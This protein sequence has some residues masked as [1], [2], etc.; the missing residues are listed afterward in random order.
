MLLFEP[1]QPLSLPGP[2]QLTLR[3]FG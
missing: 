3:L 1:L 2:F